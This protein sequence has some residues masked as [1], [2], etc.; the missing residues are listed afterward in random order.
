MSEI[1][2]DVQTIFRLAA[3]GDAKAI[4]SV[5]DDLHLRAA[6]EGYRS[7]CGIAAHVVRN[8]RA[9]SLVELADAIEGLAPP[10]IDHPA[11]KE[12]GTP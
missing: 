2:K 9:R 6:Q 5:L 1:R 4:G 10:A 3:A 7:A 11:E 12:I 8:S